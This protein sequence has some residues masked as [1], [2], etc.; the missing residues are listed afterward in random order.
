MKFLSRGLAVAALVAAGA[1]GAIAALDTELSTD[2]TALLPEDGDSGS[3]LI[4]IARRSGLLQ[5]VVI[6]VGP[7]RDDPEKLHRFTDAV[8]DELRGLDGVGR[9]ISSVD[10]ERAQR[11]AQVILEHAARL[12]RARGER[13]TRE[14]LAAR[15][16]EL[17]RSLAMPGALL[18][19]E[20]LLSDPLGLA[21][22]ALGSLEAAGAASGAHV[23]R[24]HFLNADRTHALVNA[25][26][27]ARY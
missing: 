19:G 23:E 24:G 13:P 20:Q 7:V 22:E 15:L 3:A 11:A 5:K 25:F 9:V 10:R 6:A 16:T 2:I 17:K 4:P 1:A 12:Y 18:Y 14:E 26:P 27:T 8:I 21:R